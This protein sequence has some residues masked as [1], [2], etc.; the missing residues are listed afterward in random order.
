MPSHRP[1]V[2]G[3]IDIIFPAHDHFVGAED[4]VLAALAED[5]PDRVTACQFSG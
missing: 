4:E 3:T 2:D 5:L 1:T